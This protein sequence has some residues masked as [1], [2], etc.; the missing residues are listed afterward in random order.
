MYGAIFSL[1]R[2]LGFGNQGIDL[3][4]DHFTITPTCTI[5]I[6]FYLCNFV[7]CWFRELSFHRRKVFTEGYSYY[8][9]ELEVE[10]AAWNL[11]ILI[12]LSKQAKKGTQHRLG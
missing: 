7:L 3:K 11:G 10:T 4:V 12:P 2:I 8:F 9:T 1:A 5:N 6:F